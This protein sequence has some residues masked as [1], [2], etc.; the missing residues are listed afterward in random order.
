MKS[1]LI[2]SLISLTG[3]TTAGLEYCKVVDGRLEG[4]PRMF[5]SAQACGVTCTKNAP[6]V[7]IN[8][9][10]ENCSIQTKSNT[11]RMKAI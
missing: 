7:E 3:C 6:D 8:Y 9:V 4:M 2:V 10:G 5:G 11:P 1:L